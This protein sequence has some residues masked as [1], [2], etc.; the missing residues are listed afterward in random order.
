[1]SA[2]NKKWTSAYFNILYQFMQALNKCF[3]E[4]PQ[5][6][7]YREQVKK[8]RLNKGSF[9]NIEQRIISDF[10]KNLEPITEHIVVL[11]P[12]TLQSVNELVIISKIDLVKLA[13]DVSEQTRDSILVFLYHLF[14]LG[15]LVLK[16]E[17]NLELIQKHIDHPRIIQL[18]GTSANCRVKTNGMMDT[19]FGDDQGSKILKEVLEKHGKGLNMQDL[20]SMFL[21]QGGNKKI[22]RIQD[23][24]EKKAT[25]MGMSE[26]EMELMLM[27]MANKWSGMMG[28]PKIDIDAI[29]N[30]PDQPI[31]GLGISPNDLAQMKDA[32]GNAD[33]GSAFK[34]VLG[35]L[36]KNNPATANIDVE[37]A[38]EAMQRF[39]DG[40]AKP[41]DYKMAFDKM[42][43]QANQRP[44]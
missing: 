20:F 17:D 8:F 2:Q 27:N 43:P 21:G 5:F 35:T 34:H 19:M 12:L 38:M 15:S 37:E 24:F 39:Q 22:Q 36:F 33:M 10:Y 23:A 30:N 4:Y 7:H 11:D 44:Q 28:M 32:D 42:F 25:D 14:S 9:D 1:M 6:L 26:N 13:K 16:R 40:D 31:S 29:K 18:I 41:A 3:P